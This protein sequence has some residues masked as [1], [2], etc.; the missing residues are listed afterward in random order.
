MCLI[1]AVVLAGDFA[2]LPQ[3]LIS[4]AYACHQLLCLV[5]LLSLQETSYPYHRIEGQMRVLADLAAELLCLI[6]QLSLQENLVPPPQHQW[7]D[8]D[9]CNQ[10][11]YIILLLSVQK[12]SHH[13]TASRVRC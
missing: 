3:H 2:P 8:V 1:F 12:A 4:D 7:P 5:L 11:L 13:T 6:L 10:L 9:M